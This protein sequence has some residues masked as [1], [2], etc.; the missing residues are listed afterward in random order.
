MKILDT[1]Q[2]IGLNEFDAAKYRHLKEAKRNFEL[3]YFPQ[4]PHSDSLLLVPELEALQE[5]DK[6]LLQEE[7]KLLD[8]QRR[9]MKIKE[10]ELQARQEKT[11]K[12]QFTNLQDGKRGITTVVDNSDAFECSVCY[13]RENLHESACKHTCCSSCWKG[14]LKVK[15]T[16]PICRRKILSKSIRKKK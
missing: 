2:G 5:I 14:W 9:L 8:A 16:C 7:K 4:G 12:T 6:K 15:K 1:I 11:E 10:Q 13:S 3:Y